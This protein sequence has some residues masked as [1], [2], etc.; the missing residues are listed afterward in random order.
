MF[1]HE[2]IVTLA[3]RAGQAILEVYNDPSSISVTTKD[4][5]SP[6]TEADLAAHEVIAKGLSRIDPDTPLVSEEGR[7]GTPPSLT[8]AG[9]S[10]P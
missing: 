1:D 9:W 8:P 5:D 7:L 6:L 4:D 2:S 3:P 10:I